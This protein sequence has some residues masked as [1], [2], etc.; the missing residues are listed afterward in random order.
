VTRDLGALP[1]I[2]MVLDAINLFLYN[3]PFFSLVAAFSQFRKS[4]RFD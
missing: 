1:A 2:P 3:N 4:Q